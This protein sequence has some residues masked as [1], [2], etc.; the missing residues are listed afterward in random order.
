[1]TD[2]WTGSSGRSRSTPEWDR[3]RLGVLVAYLFNGFAITAWSV[4]LPGIQERMD[5]DAATVGLFLTAGA[6]GTLVTVT[7]AGAIVARHGPKRGYGVATVGFVAAYATLALAL[8]LGSLPLLLLGNI[9]HGAAFALTNVPQSILAAA[10]ERRRGRT[11]LPQFHAAYSIGAAAGAAAGGLAAGA[12]I[13]ADA[14]FL[15]LTVIAVTVRWPIAAWFRELDGS[16]IS[17]RREE[18]AVREQQLVT[19]AD[20]PLPSPG[21]VERIGLHVWTNP[22]VLLLGT[23]ILAAALSESGANNWAAIAV[24]E[25]F[26]VSEA[27]ASVVLTVFLVAQTVMRLAGGPLI[28]RFGRAIALTAS[29]T[30]A[31]AGIMLFVLAPTEQIAVIATAL[32][33]AGSALVVPIGIAVAANDALQ[34]PARVAAVTSLASL[35]SIAGP[36]IIG[37]AASVAGV[38]PGL[39]IV[40]VAITA[41]IAIG[42]IAVRTRRAA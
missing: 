22:Q 29:S 40:A 1:V 23:M 6:G 39:G 11:I 35:A 33:G 16:V 2:R 3:G 42:P 32:W 31:L 26:N 38:R 24:V 25:S 10:S 17:A 13:S 5:A 14:Q 19:T 4:R 8:S 9:V 21:W 28:D 7:M 37:A 34:G 30:I 27:Q 41:A 12:G 36:P 18:A 15:A 20:I